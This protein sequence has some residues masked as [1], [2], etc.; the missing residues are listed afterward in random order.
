[1]KYTILVVMV[2]VMANVASATVVQ[3]I[4]ID[5]VTIGNAGNAADS[6]GFGAVG[7]DYRI[8]K[9]E[10]TNAQWDAFVSAAGEPSGNPYYAYDNNA[11]HIGTSVPA[12][13]VSWYEAAKFCNYLTSGDKHFGAYQFNN[14]DF[15]G[16]DRDF[17]ISTY[18]IAYVLP[19]EDEWYKAAYYTGSGYSTY[20]NGLNNPEA[21]TNWNWGGGSLRTP[22]DVGTGSEEQNGT[23]EM[24][25]N[26]WEWNET[27]LNSE[28]GIRGG[29]YADLELRDSSARI[30][31]I[32][33]SEQASI[34]FRVASV[35]EP[36]TLISDPNG[37][38]SLIAGTTH[39][40]IWSSTGLISNVSLEYSDANGL[41]WT[42]IEPSTPND[43]EYDWTVPEV[44]SE[45][46]LVRVSDA[47]DPNN[48][49][50][51]S[52][53][54]FTIYQCQI[55]SDADL[56]NDCKV[57]MPDLAI[58]SAGWSD[59]YD[60]NDLT[61]LADDWLRNGNPFDSGYTEPLPIMFM[62]IPSGTFQMGDSFS[63]GRSG[64][65]PVHT[66][67]LSSFQMSKYE[68]T[69]AQYC[70]YLNSAYPGQIKEVGGIIYAASDTG[71][72][73][74]YFDT[75]TVSSD[76]QIDSSGG[77]FTVLTKGGR[78][79]SDD[80]VVDVSWY[81]AEAFCD[82]YGYALPTEAQWEYA[83]RGGLSGNRFPWGD[84]INHDYANYRA[85]GSTY[86]YDTSPYTSYTY[87]PTWN[88]GIRPYTSP[89]G[90]FAAN[91]YGLHDM[92]GNVWEWCADRDGS[93]SPGSQTNPTGPTTGSYRVLRGGSC[94]SKGANNCRVAR[95]NIHDPSDRS[96]YIGF[97]VCLD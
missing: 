32:P 38:E 73:S 45:Q 92:A 16:I 58:V 13:M 23:F 35:L 25:G 57:T 71:N 90:S 67:T 70:D 48:V 82:Y 20:A 26:I 79:M 49:F 29:S 39:P 87:H 93:Y 61:A 75:R 84:T 53:D 64:E 30:F 62:P 65:L 46:C 95:R 96:R 1:M 15:M 8:G 11:Y 33:G 69:N 2:L 28:Y 85:N 55:D 76:S 47:T 21:T 4:N 78:D 59:V 3:G 43:G 83:A 31:T 68:I 14:G 34:G 19:T 97:H 17:A 7:Y 94:S 77:V 42:E 50:D 51:V 37:G 54:V 5:F 72:S 66:V 18:G 86:S 22:W 40:I 74:P 12:N 24:M 81:G 41:S 36:T 91:G 10:I 88:D 89:V 9:Y 63:E 6:T 60:I 56:N 27:Q 80:P 52:D 44:N